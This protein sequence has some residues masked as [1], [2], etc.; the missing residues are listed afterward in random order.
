MSALAL[1]DQRAVRRQAPQV[2]QITAARFGQPI[3]VNR[4]RLG[5]RRLASPVHRLGGDRIDGTAG[6]QEHRD[7]QAMRGLN[8]TGQLR[9]GRGGAQRLLQKGGPLGESLSGMGLP[10]CRHPLPLLVN[11]HP[12]V[13]GVRPVNPGIPQRS[14]WPPSSWPLIG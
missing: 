12:I 1:L 7:E 11:D 10:A 4:V 13:M 5:S 6:V 3:R 14:R 9:W 2:G 8:Q